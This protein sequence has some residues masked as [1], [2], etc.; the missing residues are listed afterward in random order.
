MR[1]PSFI[2]VGVA[3]CATSYTFKQLKIHNDCYGNQ[4]EINLFTDFSEDKFKLYCKNFESDKKIV[5]EW[6]P[7][8]F[9][10]TD[11]AKLMRKWVPNTKIIINLRNPTDRFISWW[12]HKKR[13]GKVTE[14]L[15]ECWEKYPNWK[16]SGFYYKHIPKWK[17]NFNTLINF[18]DEINRNSYWKKLYSFLEIDFVKPNFYDLSKKEKTPIYFEIQSFYKESVKELENYL[19]KDLSH[20][21]N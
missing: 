11:A 14:T 18:Y 16:E 12:E 3:R 20:W 7:R 9:I 10:R 6:S 15:E 13:N 19:K 21:I 2:G 5:G 1:K 4:K 8:Y 17:D